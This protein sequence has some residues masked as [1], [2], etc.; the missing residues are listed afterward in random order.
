MAE[1]KLR[2]HKVGGDA[3]LLETT[4]GK[5]QNIEGLDPQVVEKA[6][7]DMEVYMKRDVQSN[8]KLKDLVCKN[9][10]RNCLKKVLAKPTIC[11]TSW[12]EKECAPLCQSCHTL[13][14]NHRCPLDD[15][16]PDSVPA[17]FVNEMFERIVTDE[18]YRKNYNPAV[19]SKPISF[20]AVSVTTDKELY[21]NATGADGPWIVVLDNFLSADECERMK[22]MGQAQG[23]EQSADV[24][25]MDYTGSITSNFNEGRT[26][27]NAWCMGKCMTDPVSQSV[28]SRMVKLTGIPDP[29]HEFFQILKYTVGQHYGRHH[30]FADYHLDR[31]YG[32]R[33]LTV[34]LYLNTVEDGG[35]THFS[36][37]NLTVVPKQGRAVIWPSVLS[38]KPRDKDDRTDHEALPVKVGVKYGANAWIHQKDF[39]KEHWK[40]CV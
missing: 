18:D 26:S 16:I 1:D 36:E 40:N 29:N 2:L 17:G 38:D 20:D 34:F 13:D 24:G 39:K 9:R 7:Q 25:A 30:D 10:D 22:E 11:S 27:K 35:G 15:S 31:Q 32:P 21:P 3:T 28:S 37:L 12:M 8:P 6:M 33:V 4:H 23:Y 19:L 5:D 14:F